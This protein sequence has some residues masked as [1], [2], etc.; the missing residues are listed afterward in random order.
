MRSG[1]LEPAILRVRPLVPLQRFCRGQL[2]GG[3][4]GK[5]R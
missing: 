3:S 5:L 2:D 1:P 4:A